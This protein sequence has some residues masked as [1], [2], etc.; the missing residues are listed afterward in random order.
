M[1]H[2]RK[3]NKKMQRLTDSKVKP[4][5]WLHIAFIGSAREYGFAIY[6][7]DTRQVIEIDSIEVIDDEIKNAPSP[8]DNHKP[9]VGGGSIVKNFNKQFAQASA[10][11]NK[12]KD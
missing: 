9:L 7:W 3:Y 2:I 5:P 12:F 10:D 4:E 11:K 8:P 1:L 6:V